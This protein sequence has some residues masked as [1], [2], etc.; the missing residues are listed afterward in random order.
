METHTLAEAPGA[1]SSIPGEA[2][3]R[4]VLI[5]LGAVL[6]IALLLGAGYVGIETSAYSRSMAK[7]YSIPLPSI[8]RSTDTLVIARGRHL[9]ES[10][11]GCAGAD[12]HGIDLGG[13]N[14]I[15][16]GPVGRVTAPNITAGGAGGEYSDAEIARLILHGVRRDGTS[17]RFMPAQDLAWLPDADV[18]AIVSYVR[19]MP[20]VQ[21][22]NG[23]FEIGLLGKVLDRHDLFVVDVARRIDHEHRPSAPAPAPTAAY[24]E[25]LAHSCAGCHGEHLSGGRMPGAPA[26]MA[27]PLNLTPDATGLQG[28]TFKDFERVLATG[29][30]KD[31]RKLD[32]LMPFAEIAKMD[33]TE[34]RAIW[35]YLQSQPPLPFGSR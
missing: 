17:V 31:G 5:W 12:C 29:T 4:K 2:V 32:P 21:K 35:A 15:D 10:V 11:A 9:A 28:W 14:T 1:P 3:V 20:A 8:E 22:P 6:G 34:K 26:S 24:G 27:I 19:S 7:V 33:E 25:F 23:P 13:G 30:R 18:A 16:A